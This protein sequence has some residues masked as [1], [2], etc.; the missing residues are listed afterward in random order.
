MSNLELQEVQETYELGQERSCDTCARD[1]CGYESRPDYI[2]T[3]SLVEVDFV[4]LAELY[5][6]FSD[7][8]RLKILYTLL[9]NDMT[10]GDI[11]ESL[12]MSQSAVSHQLKGLRASR[13]VKYEKLGKHVVYTL[14]DDHVRSIFERGM[15]HILHA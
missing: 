14:D 5:K 15:E 4:E 12:Q 3:S 7:P 8:S 10:V 11:A 9:K 6:S 13:L 1:D 2:G